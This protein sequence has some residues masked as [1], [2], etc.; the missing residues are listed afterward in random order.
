MAIDCVNESLRENALSSLGAGVRKLEST[1]VGTRHGHVN[2]AI[3][4]SEYDLAR[5]YGP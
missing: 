3:N 5:V 1:S 4:R 2:G